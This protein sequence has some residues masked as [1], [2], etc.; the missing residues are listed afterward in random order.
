[1]PEGCG[2]ETVRCPACQTTF[3]APDTTSAT[4]GT[5]GTLAEDKARVGLELRRETRPDRPG[6]PPSGPVIT[7]EDHRPW[8]LVG[9]G[10]GWIKLGVYF[11]M[12][13][14]LA[15]GLWL[16]QMITGSDVGWE[17]GPLPLGFCCTWFLL[18]PAAVWTTAGLIACRRFPAEGPGKALCL[19]A[20]VLYLFLA[21]PR[22]LAVLTIYGVPVV[23]RGWIGR[24]ITFGHFLAL[25]LFFLF[26]REV[27]Q[28]LRHQPTLTR[29]RWLL[30]IWIAV[31]GLILAHSV[32]EEFRGY[33][34]AF[35]AG[36]LPFDE[37]WVVMALLDLAWLALLV[38]Q[39]RFLHAARRAVYGYLRSIGADTISPNEASSAGTE[40]ASR[41][42]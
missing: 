9:T 13:S 12:P 4:A 16:L 14:R 21:I 35:F 5:R 15:A 27:G 1:V 19:A 2:G 22:L 42:P 29:F 39:V 31:L 8:E 25:G 28:A 26:V 33:P 40:G 3:T 7:C 32:L 23:W 36:S 41:I 20:L 11:E 10:L 24:G 38:Q 17:P 6:A 37:E 30:G 34:P 18:L